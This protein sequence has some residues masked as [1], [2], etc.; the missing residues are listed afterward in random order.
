MSSR[1]S[2]FLVLVGTILVAFTNWYLIFLFARAGDGA[3]SVGEY[4]TILSVA[5]PIFVVFQLGLRTI[6][7]S[8]RRKFSWKLYFWLRIAG[9]ILAVLFVALWLCRVSEIPWYLTFSVLCLKFANSFD[10]IYQA[11]LQYSGNMK[12]LGVIMIAN[13]LVTLFAATIGVLVGGRIEYGILSS[14]VVSAC[15][16]FWAGAISRKVFDDALPFEWSQLLELFKACTPVTISQFFASLLFQI[17]VLLLS[18]T[19]DSSIVGLYTSAAYLLTVASLIG[20]TLQTVLITPLREMLE[21]TTAR[22]VYERVVKLIVRIFAWSL[23]ASL[24]VVALGDPVLQL[25]Y[26]SDFGVGPVALFLLITACTL[27][28]GAYICSVGLNVINRYGKVTASMSISCIIS[29]L[30]GLVYIHLIDSLVIAGFATVAVGALARATTM[31][32]YF[33][34][35]VIEDSPHP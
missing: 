18:S 27:T 6:L 11:R 4:S 8:Y 14:A 12:M 5:T 2:G 34:R 13:G 1:R 35:A 21:S 24:L 23:P 33:R 28:I 9:A 19:G 10:D 15:T 3:S 32:L 20:S 29:F 16:A 17:P 30:S 26:G 31:F 22:S 25:I 7:V